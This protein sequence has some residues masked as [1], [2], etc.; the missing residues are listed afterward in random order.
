MLHVY[1]D[2]AHRFTTLKIEGS[3]GEELYRAR[4]TLDAI[5]SGLTLTNGGHALWNSS[6]SSNGAAYN[7][8]KIIGKELGL[9]TTR[10]K[11]KRQ[12]QFFGPSERYQQAVHRITDM[13]KEELSTS[14]EIGLKEA[15]FSWAIHGGFKTVDQVLGKNVAVFDVLSKTITINGTKK[16]WQ[17]WKVPMH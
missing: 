9:L 10:D 17:L 15:Q 12:L 16:P 14:F 1:P 6:L 2:T 8:L 7:K 3:N 4:K 5:L 13:L 11:S